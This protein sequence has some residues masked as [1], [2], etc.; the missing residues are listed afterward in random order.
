MQEAPRKWGVARK[1]LAFQYLQ[2]S[3]E[4]ILNGGIKSAINVSPTITDDGMPLF[5]VNIGEANF[6]SIAAWFARSIEQSQLI[7]CGYPGFAQGSHLLAR[8]TGPPFPLPASPMTLDPAH[9]CFKP[10]WPQFQK[11]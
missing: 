3:L 9:N 11:A 2:N 7:G 8:L 1:Q 6:S 10:L 4:K 5:T